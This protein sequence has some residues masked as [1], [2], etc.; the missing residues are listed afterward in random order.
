LNNTL[1]LASARNTGVPGSLAG[2]VA[3]SPAFQMF[4]SFLDNIQVDFLLRAT[5]L[6]VR[7]SIVDAP[8]LVVYNGRQAQ[9]T[10]GTIQNYVATP[11]WQPAGAGSVSGSAAPGRDPQISSTFSGRTLDVTATVTADR[12]Y[13][14]MT[15]RPEQQITTGFDTFPTANGPVQLPIRDTVNI[16]TNATVPDGGWLLLGGLKIAGETETDAGV[17]FLSKIPILKRAY[18]NRSHVKDEQIILILIKPTILIPDEAEDRAYPDM[19][20]AE[21][22]AS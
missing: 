18:T 22:M 21:A 3:G 2:E 12:K 14:I 11:G 5:Q 17:P 10:I 16:S 20:T 8:R 13:V 7:S 19:A 6:D 1:G 15:V 4:G 9:I